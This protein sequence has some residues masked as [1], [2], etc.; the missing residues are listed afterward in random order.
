MTF[1]AD[2]LEKI[3]LAIDV[4]IKHQYIDIMGKERSFSQFMKREIKKI[5]KDNVKDAKWLVF[6]EVF[7]HYASDNL[8]VRK[9]SISRFVKA[10][11][12]ALLVDS[13]VV[14]GP[15]EPQ[16]SD[17]FKKDIQYARGVGPK[18]AYLFNKL[19]IFTIYDLLYYFPKKYLDYSSRVLI[20]DLQ[21]GCGAT[22]FGHISSTNSFTTKN[23]LSIVKVVIKDES[24]SMNLSF[25]YGKSNKFLLD[26]YRLQYPKGASVMVSG[27]VKLD[28]FT[29]KP[30]ID[31]PEFQLITGD[32]EG[33]N[34]SGS[35]HLGR[36]VPVYPLV[37]N[38]NI[39]TLRRAIHNA[40]NDYKHCLYNIIPDEIVKKYK[41]LDRKIAIEQIHFPQ[42]EELYQQA[43]YYLVFEELFLMQLRLGLLRKN[44]RDKFKSLEIKRK[45]GGLTDKFLRSLPFELT[46]AQK[47]AIDIISKDINSQIPMQRLLQG[48]VGSGKTVV[49]TVMLLSAIENGFQSAIMAPTEILATQHFN[50][51]ITSLT[52]LGV[53]IG[54]FLGSNSKKMRD[55]LETGLRNGQI[56]LAIGTHAL[57]Q[58]KIEFKKLGA[59]VIDEQHKFGVGQRT[60]L[61]RKG[62]CPQL[63]S[64]SATPIPRTL[65]LTVHAD[66]DL[67]IIDEMPIG[68]IPIKT[69]LCTSNTRKQAY[70]L[71]RKEVEAGHQAYI[72]YPLIEESETLSAKA[73]AKEAKILQ[74]GEFRAYKVGLL[75]GKLKAS[76]KEQVMQDFKNKKYDI[77]VST[78]VV[79]VGVDIKNATVM[80]IEDAQRFGLSQLHQ[81]RGRV[82]RSDLQSYCVLISNS[83]NPDTKERLE[84]LTQTNDGFIIAEKDLQIRGPGEFLGAKQSGLDEL[85]L[86]D[87]VKDVKIIEQTKQAV[88]DYLENLSDIKDIDEKLALTLKQDKNSGLFSLE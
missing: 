1:R 55:Q 48:D 37:E 42:N 16:I 72:V 86:T 45:K 76:E 12:T 17:I 27:I 75:H 25:F 73:A 8:P 52:P 22:V 19:D 20:K 32:F 56:H 57:I 3:K 66:L 67:T 77:L 7:E 14:D 9:K 74:E 58:E 83:S 11:K 33:E 28:K 51:L 81:L 85:S 40:I 13:N 65:A 31:K 34:G 38:L 15:E 79:E 43:R 64:M 82:G 49:A 44:V 71:I 26:R 63:L 47:S 80:V 84:V 54:L 60:K 88:K 59:V 62:I 23:G 69:A 70:N 68:R 53:N 61:T 87:L 24:G 30:T 10:L 5:Y 39:K 35:L 4:E 6:L 50:N 21:I 2:N 29:Q 41:L 46:N 18:I 36:I 78:T